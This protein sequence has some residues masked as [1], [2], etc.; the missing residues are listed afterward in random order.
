MEELFEDKR[1]WIIG[2]ACALVGV[3]V[4][5]FLAPLTH[6][7]TINMWSNN[8]IGSGKNFTHSTTGGNSQH[9]LASNKNNSAKASAKASK[10]DKKKSGHHNCCSGKH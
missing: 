2:A 5:L 6:G 8:A 9:R 3:V 10:A 4:G 7:I 1:I